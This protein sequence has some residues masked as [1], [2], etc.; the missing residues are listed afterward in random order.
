VVDSTVRIEDAT[1]VVVPII[2]EF[3]VVNVATVF[4]EFPI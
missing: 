4:V 1:S 2:K 3:E